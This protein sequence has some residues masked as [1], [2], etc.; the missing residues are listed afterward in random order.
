MNARA[1]SR[2]FDCADTGIQSRVP[3]GPRHARTYQLVPCTCSTGRVF[4]AASREVH[5]EPG[6]REASAFA[7]AEPHAPGT[8][9]PAAAAAVTSEVSA[10]PRADQ[11]VVDRGGS[12]GPN[13]VRSAYRPEPEGGL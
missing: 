9:S 6:P 2:C 13:G 7:A 4:A 5:N 1:V 8:T 3:V 10:P 11:P 12:S